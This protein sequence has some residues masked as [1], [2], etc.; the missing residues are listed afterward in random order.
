[1]KAS[2]LLKIVDVEDRK[3][4]MI[5]VKLFASE[6][7]DIP[8]GLVTGIQVGV[9][10]VAV[11]AGMSVAAAGFVAI[12]P[13]VVGVAIPAGVAVAHGF[14][15][16]AEKS[17]FFKWLETHALAIN[18]SV[19]HHISVVIETI[20]EHNIHKFWS[21]EKLTHGIVIQCATTEERLLEKYI[22]SQLHG[23]GD[24]KG[25]FQV[26]LET[27]NC[28]SGSTITSLLS[29][30]FDNG[31]QSKGYNLLTDN[32]KG[33]GKRLFE[34]VAQEKAYPSFLEIERAIF[35]DIK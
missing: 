8:K 18:D 4:D 28:K 25:V 35:K 7:P 17:G 33:F 13:H 5:S 34:S 30:I 23:E 6:L 22:T 3:A 9:G 19:F 20:T 12:G 29:W 15:K 10:T 2:K 11:V 21:F 1:L 31:E 14:V 27:D 32:C 16:G 24:R 26:P